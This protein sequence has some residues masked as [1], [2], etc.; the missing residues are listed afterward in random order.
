MSEH[1]SA[2]LR[3]LL[4]SSVVA[5]SVASSSCYDWQ[6]GATPTEGGVT[7]DA[8]R[9]EAA[10]KDAA[11][12]PDATVNEPDAALLGD[13]VAPHADAHDASE[14]GALEANVH[15]AHA[16]AIRCASAGLPCAGGVKNECG[17]SVYVPDLASPATMT[18]VMAVKALASGGC[19]PSCSGACP[20]VTES[21]C[22]TNETDAGPVTACFQGEPP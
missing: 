17:C 12:Q 6:L 8:T 18:Y 3:R 16:N 13:A 4:A 20:P 19:S 21:V 10:T 14:C 7:G 22:L 2:W 15:A 11:A 9:T 5:C 1:T